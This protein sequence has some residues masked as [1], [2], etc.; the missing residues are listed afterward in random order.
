MKPRRLKLQAMPNP[1]NAPA[2]LPDSYE[3]GLQ[4]LETLVAQLDS[5]QLPL[6]AL[7]TQYQRGAAL[8]Q[9]CKDKLQAVEQQIQV[10]EDTEFKPW[11]PKA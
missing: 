9:F 10:F 8:L 4:E 6:D 11:T 2:P 1:S 5:G 7:L 3:A